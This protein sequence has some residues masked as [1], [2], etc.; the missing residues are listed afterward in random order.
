M[1]VSFHKPPEFSKLFFIFN[2]SEEI[3]MA[4][5]IPFQ[6]KVGQI[7]LPMRYK[8]AIGLPVASNPLNAALKSNH[9]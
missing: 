1:I 6:N 2:L 8:F 7:M 4:S 3:T 9:S 5:S